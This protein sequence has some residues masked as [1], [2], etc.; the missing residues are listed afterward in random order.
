MGSGLVVF[1]NFLGN[2]IGVKFAFVGN[3]NLATFLPSDNPFPQSEYGFHTGSRPVSQLDLPLGGGGTRYSV[4][5]HQ[6]CSRQDLADLFEN[7]I[8]RR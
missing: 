3:D 5:P 4:T 8:I 6:V 2:G 1:P 7:L